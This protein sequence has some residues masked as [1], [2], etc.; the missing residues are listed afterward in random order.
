MATVSIA[1]LGLGRLG[2][3]VGLALK[4]YNAS[5]DAQHTFEIT[6]ADT[7]A[8]VREEAQKIG[9]ADKIERDVIGVAANKDIVILAL[10]YADVQVAYKALGRELRSGA[11]LLD[12]SPLKQPSLEWAKTHLH[13]EA[14]QVGITPIVNPNYLFDGLDDTLHATPDLFDNSNMLLMPSVTCSKEAVELAAD[15][16]I[17]L[18]AKPHFVDPVEHDSLVAATEGLPAVLGLATFYMMLK[19]RGWHDYQRLTNPSFG[20]L[21]HHLHDTHPDDLR[22]FLLLNRESLVRQIDQLVDTLGTFRTVLA[23]NDRAAL[24][25]ALVESGD[26]YD[27]W[28]NRR[29]NGKWDDNPAEAKNPSIGNMLMT[30]FMGSFLTR[31]ISGAKN[32]DDKES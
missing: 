20:R 6:P 19:S 2:A 28:L 9:L 30:G 29:H 1:I 27:T 22:D 25:S 17:L 15:F 26:A 7:R 4:R 12:M 8:G 31:R 5:K 10:P 13:P 23:A 18:G 24:E 21:S 16:S 11:V 14:H 32:G 3:S